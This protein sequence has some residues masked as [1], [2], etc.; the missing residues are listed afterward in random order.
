MW[1]MYLNSACAAFRFGELDLWQ[2]TFT[3]G[4]SSEMPLTRRHL[5]EEQLQ[6]APRLRRA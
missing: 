4:Y 5:Y 6:Q 2:I 3:H 1:R